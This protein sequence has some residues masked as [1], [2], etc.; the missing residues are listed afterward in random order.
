MRALLIV[1]L[2]T[3]LCSACSFQ[4]GSREIEKSYIDCHKTP[5]HRQCPRHIELGIK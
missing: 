5:E 3:V 2:L 1:F 4:I